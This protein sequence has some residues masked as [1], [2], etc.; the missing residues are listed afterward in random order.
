[1]TAAATKSRMALSSMCRDGKHKTCR[2]IGMRCVCECHHQNGSDPPGGVTPRRTAAR[3]PLV[4]L[5]KADPPPPPQPTRKPNLSEQVRPLLEQ[6]LVTGD[7]D[8]FR[9]ALF[10]KTR[11]AAMNLKRVRESHSQRDWEWRAARLEEVDQ[12]AL[13]V[14]WI[15]KERSVL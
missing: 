9:V 5:V 4:R 15:G 6:I 13:Y 8:W 11:Q 12:S 1:V 14:R 7:R 3:P 2:D 10:F